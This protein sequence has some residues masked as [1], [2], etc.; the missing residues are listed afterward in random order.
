MRRKKYG[1]IHSLLVDKQSINQL[2]FLYLK[3]MSKR[4][5]LKLQV[6]LYSVLFS[7]PC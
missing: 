4:Y 5:L 6:L 2:I 3:A 1:L 7:L